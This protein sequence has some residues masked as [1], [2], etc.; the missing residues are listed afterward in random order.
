MMTF[1]SF[2]SYQFWEKIWLHNC[3]HLN[4]GI[5]KL[6]GLAVSVARLSYRQ[7]LSSEHPISLLD[8]RITMANLSNRQNFKPTCNSVSRRHTIWSY[9]SI[10]RNDWANKQVWTGTRD[11]GWLTSVR[12]PVLWRRRWC[13]M[14]MAVARLIAVRMAVIA[15]RLLSSRA[16]LLVGLPMLLLQTDAHSERESENQHEHRSWSWAPLISS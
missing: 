12:V 16:L 2:I 10:V 5:V 7:E 4:E 8:K 9:G 15:C 13:C 6:C 11:C 1:T 3:R 14:A